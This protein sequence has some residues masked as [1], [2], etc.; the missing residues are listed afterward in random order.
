M[1]KVI[2][3]ARFVVA[4]NAKGQAWHDIL[5]L[6]SERLEEVALNPDTYLAITEGP[7]KAWSRGR[8]GDMIFVGLDRDEVDGLSYQEKVELKEVFCKE[9]ADAV[10]SRARERYFRERGTN[11]GPGSI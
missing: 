10:V 6:P 7:L 8:K 5:T 11:V 3:K 1:E 4:A 2:A 9:Y